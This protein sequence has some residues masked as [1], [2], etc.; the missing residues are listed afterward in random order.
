MQ[1]IVVFCIALI[2]FFSKLKI[3]YNGNENEDNLVLKMR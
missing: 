3:T 1:I 2:D